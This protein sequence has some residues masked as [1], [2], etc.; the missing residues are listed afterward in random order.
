MKSQGASPQAIAAI[1]GNWSVESSIN[2]K[3]AEGDYLSPPVG[4]TDSSWDD[5]AWL[6]IG[7]PAIYG[8]AYP[9]ILHRGL[10]LGQW[11]DTADGSTRHTALLNYARTQNK[12][13][14]DL[15]LQLDFMLH[16]DSPYY[17]SWLKDFFKKYGQCSQSR[18]TLPHLLG[19]KFWRQTTGKTN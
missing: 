10:G 15:D 3:R 2:P 1:L 5:E 9:N 19:G 8:G 4:A 6:A 11:T 13:W 16:G 12:K 18:P 17:Q 7:G 14:Y